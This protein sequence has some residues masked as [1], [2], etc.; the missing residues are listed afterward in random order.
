MRMSALRLRSV[1]DKLKTPQVST[2]CGVKHKQPR[3]IKVIL[4]QAQY[5]KMY[6]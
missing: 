3:L 6:K 4:R 5:D 2:T 1:P